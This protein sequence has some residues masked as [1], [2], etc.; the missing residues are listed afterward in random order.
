M[1]RDGIT[2]IDAS[3]AP[4]TGAAL[5]RGLF[6]G[7]AAPHP[8]KGLLLCPTGLLRGVAARQAVAAG[9]A[10]PLAGSGTAFSSVTVFLRPDAETPP[11]HV[12]TADLGSLTAWAEDHGPAMVA[13]MGAVL[14][15]LC[16]VRAP[17]AGLTLDRPR[18]MGI[19]N[20][21][22]DSFSDG[23]DH[24]AARDAIARGLAMLEAGADLIDVGGES[25]RPGAEPVDP[26]EER[27]RVLPVV[28]ALAARGAVVSIDTRHARVMEAAL[29]HG[30]TIV[31]DVTALTHDP[32]ALATVARARASVIL[33]HIRGEPRSMQVDPTYDRAPADVYAWLARRVALCQSA[34][35]PPGRLCVDPGIGFGKMLDHNL[36]LLHHIGLFHGL[37]CAVALGASR[38]SF[39]ARAA[40]AVDAEGR[41]TDH[42]K[43]RLGGSLAAALS[44]VEQGVQILRVHDVPETVQAVTVAMGIRDGGS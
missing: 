32:E 43:A 41:P 14:A 12:H 38:K 16:S 21:T 19:V 8:L 31:N 36:D 40:G 6:R 2:S 13:I 42:P 15:R 7:G 17:F 24:F 3:S 26:E 18:V 30:A 33:M 35:I 25:T 27:R 37:G 9:R 20:C 29:D 34:G 23:G 44:A 11:W 28:K 1:Q 22:P 5:P 10:R 39:I 4:S